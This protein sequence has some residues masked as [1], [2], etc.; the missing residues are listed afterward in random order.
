MVTLAVAMAFFV[1]VTRSMLLVRQTI[2]LQSRQAQAECL[3]ASACRR[4]EAKRAQDAKYT[5]ET[6]RLSPAD[7]GGRDGAVVQIRIAAKSDK[8]DPVI[9]VDADYPDDP[10]NRA[11][12]SR[13]IKIPVSKGSKK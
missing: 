2:D 11:R 13:E 7:M 5:G 8:D 12:V 3:A 9:H 6:W 1:G 10:F 4:A